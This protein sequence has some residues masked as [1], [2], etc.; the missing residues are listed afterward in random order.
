M[1]N[2]HLEVVQLIES[3][4]YQAGVGDWTGAAVKGYSHILRLLLVKHGADV[5]RDGESR[6]LL[7]GAILAAKII[8]QHDTDLNRRRSDH[9]MKWAI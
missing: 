8:L 5:N 6:N 9:S 3:K 7:L 1:E 2:S 4:L